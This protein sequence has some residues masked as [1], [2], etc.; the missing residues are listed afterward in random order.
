MRL[1]FVDI[2]NVNRINNLW[3]GAR[4][5]FQIT[6][7]VNQLTLLL[8]TVFFCHSDLTRLLWRFYVFTIERDWSMVEMDGV[9][10]GFSS[11]YICVCAPLFQQCPQWL[12][13]F[14]E[15]GLHGVVFANAL[16]CMHS[17]YYTQY[18]P[19]Y[20]H[21]CLFRCINYGWNTSTTWFSCND[22]E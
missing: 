18:I 8:L 10:V 19:C 4:Y 6:I 5:Q 22:F 21:F 16:S 15:F 17:T 14:E 2:V 11:F 3:F 20:A 12:V 7:E 1:Q 13:W 9:C